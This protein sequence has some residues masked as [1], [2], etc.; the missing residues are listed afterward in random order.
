MI[1]NCMKC[2]FCVHKNITPLDDF[3]NFH[4]KRCLNTQYL[5]CSNFKYNYK[6]WLIFDIKSLLRGIK[7]KIK[8]KFTNKRLENIEIRISKLENIIRRGEK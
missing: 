8:K 4:K 3:C 5:L 2:I 6:V 7:Y 1:K